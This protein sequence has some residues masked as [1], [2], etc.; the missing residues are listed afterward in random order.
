MAQRDKSDFDLQLHLNVQSAEGSHAIKCSSPS[1]ISPFLHKIRKISIM[2]EFAIPSECCSEECARCRVCIG[3]SAY[4][5]LA[6]IDWRD[7]VETK[8]YDAPN[9]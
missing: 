6:K 2:A 5:Q 9:L 4:G 1:I 8:G 3:G 7:K